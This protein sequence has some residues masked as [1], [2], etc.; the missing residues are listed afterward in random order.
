MA[1]LEVTRSND[2]MRV[3]ATRMLV[4]EVGRDDSGI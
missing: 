4:K 2:P 3:P 1:S